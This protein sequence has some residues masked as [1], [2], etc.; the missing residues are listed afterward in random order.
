M[1]LLTVTTTRPD[2]SYEFWWYSGLQPPGFFNRDNSHFD[3]GDMISFSRN[4]DNTGLICTRELLFKDQAAFL[5]IITE[6]QT[7][8]PT[9]YDEKN[10][11][12]ALHGHVETK[13]YTTV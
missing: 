13:V 7:L 5:K 12:N 4:I 6:D 9:I 1:Y 3:V 11:Y 2:T 8:Y 10:A